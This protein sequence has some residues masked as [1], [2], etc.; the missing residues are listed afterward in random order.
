MLSQTAEYALRAVLYIAGRPPETS[1]RVPE[2]ARATG[3]PRNYLA[4]T[5]HQLARV[6]VLRSTRGPRGGFRLAE[7]AEAMTIDRVLAPFAAT[8]TRR[9]LLHDR[10]CG[11]RPC[12][13]HTR[14]APVARRLDHFFGTTTVA[15]LAGGAEG[16]PALDPTLH[17]SVTDGGLT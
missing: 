2:L 3:V 5:L 13:A 9:C 7:P 12:A 8:D 1:I 10:P 14:W 17:P 4:K 11:V 6:G 15:D 16:A